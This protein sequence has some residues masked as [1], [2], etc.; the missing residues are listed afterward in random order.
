MAPLL[1][2]LR[3]ISVDSKTC[4][5]KSIQHTVLRKEQGD[6]NK[7]LPLNGLSWGRHYSI[8]IQISRL[9][10]SLPIPMPPNVVF[11]NYWL[12]SFSSRML[13]AVD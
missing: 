2:H 1:Q 11:L 6:W 12:S 7:H 9:L 13:F 8:A 3:C 4:E 5:L 10:S